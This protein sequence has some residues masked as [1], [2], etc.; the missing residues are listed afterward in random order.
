MKTI[1]HCLSGSIRFMI[2][3]L[4]CTKELKSCLFGLLLVCAFSNTSR[5]QSQNSPLDS[6]V[7][8]DGGMC[9][10][11]VLL[12]DTLDL[13]NIEVSLGSK[14]SSTDIVD[15]IFSFDQ[16]TGL[17]TGFSYLRTNMQVF[18]GLGD[19]DLPAAFNAKV[20]LKNSAGNWSS[21]FEYVSN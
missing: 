10:V 13:S 15:H 21:W 16:I 19:L 8:V 12:E 7:N 18:L 5:A 9:N 17:P 4:P 2:K 11:F 6:Y 3:L 1:L 14:G 20:R